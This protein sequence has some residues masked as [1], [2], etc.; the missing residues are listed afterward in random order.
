MQ[1]NIIDIYENYFDNMIPSELTLP[2]NVR[3][4]V[5]LH[6][7]YRQNS[8]FASFDFREIAITRGDGKRI[9]MSR[10]FSRIESAANR[11]HEMMAF[12]DLDSSCDSS[13]SA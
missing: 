8:D 10:S 1:N 13:R 6:V 9:A 11:E 12:N 7:L 4:V 3:Y 5:T 2:R